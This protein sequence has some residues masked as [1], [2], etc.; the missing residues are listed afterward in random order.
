MEIHFVVTLLATMKAMYQMSRSL[1]CLVSYSNKKMLNS[2]G[3]H[4]TL[5]FQME[6]YNHM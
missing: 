6:L 1:A 3:R 4:G 5:T 2:R